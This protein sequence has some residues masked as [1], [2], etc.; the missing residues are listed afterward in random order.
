MF[1]MPFG[2]SFPMLSGGL[3][4]LFSSGGGK[5]AP[6]GGGRPAGPSVMQVGEIRVSNTGWQDSWYESLA[7]RNARLEARGY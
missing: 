3:D 4:K 2:A 6:G 7:P 1:G 5:T